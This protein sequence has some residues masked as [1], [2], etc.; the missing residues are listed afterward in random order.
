[1][2]LFFLA[3]G[4]RVL[5]SR[6]DMVT[7]GDALLELTG[8]PANFTVTAAGRDLTAAFRAGSPIGRIADLPLGKSS[9][10]VRQG[11]REMAK[12]ELTNYPIT[13]P[14]FSGPHQIPY[15]CQPESVQLGSPF[16]SLCSLPATIRYYYRAAGGPITGG[17]EYSAGPFQYFKPYDSNAP[18]PADMTQTT[19]TDGRTVDF[20][21]RR[22]IGT[23]NR[24]IYSIAFLH[25]PGDPLPDPWTKTP[26]WNGWL[27][28]S[29]GGGC[30]P[31]Y[32]QASGPLPMTEAVLAQGFAEAGSSLTTFGTNCNDV[33]SAEAMMMVKEHFIKQYGVPVHT[34]GNGGSGGTMQ[35]LLIAQNYPGLLDGLST[36]I[37][38]PDTYSVVP[39]AV[40]CSLLA[41]AFNGAS[42]Q[43]TREQM[44]AVSGY[45]KW[46][47]CESWFKSGYSPGW[48]NASRCRGVAA[49][50][51]YHPVKNPG[52]VRCDLYSNQEAYWGRDPKTGFA[53]RA[54][55]NIGVQYGLKAF[56]EGRISS[57]QFIELNE[58]IGGF[59]ADGNIVPARMS[60]DREALLIA[61]RTG[62]INMGGGSLGSIPIV[63]MRGY[64]DAIGNFHDKFRTYQLQARMHAAHGSAN[65]LAIFVQPPRD[66]KPLLILKKW[67]DDGKR[68]PE[69]ADACWDKGQK[70]VESATYAGPGKC[71]ELYPAHGDPRM[72]AGAPLNGTTLKCALKPLPTK[73]LTEAQ[74]LRLR[75][76][77]PDGV[78]D[79]TRPGVEEQL[80]STTWQRFG[81]G[82]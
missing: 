64:R 49:D 29:F 21:V 48:V 40:D 25:R 61:Y 82:F 33:L 60:A 28:Y 24:G 27:V 81:N 76:V 68:P 22:E 70:I 66:F 45:S 56:Q 71:N 41:N 19:T 16:D 39:G 57:D 2:M 5:S 20:I 23:I 34:L 58:R 36:D 10:V 35:Q 53:R 72:A 46:E 6:P 69:A 31:G 50:K 17:P 9:V 8:V 14:V 32:R 30:E 3:A 59:D 38:Y 47:V 79:Y 54:L 52:G 74:L 77:F 80:P 73:P 75:A 65:N 1:M 15:L 12:L 18:R 43:W 51:V 55:D 44:G 42:Q 13:G 63:D 11:K 62:R 37:G 4:L 26:S 78:C 67:V 7:G